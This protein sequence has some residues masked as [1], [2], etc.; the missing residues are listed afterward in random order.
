MQAV[1]SIGGYTHSEA[2]GSICLW[3]CSPIYYFA[4]EMVSL[5]PRSTLVNIHRVD[6]GIKTFRFIGLRGSLSLVFSEFLDYA[7]M[8]ISTG[9]SFNLLTQLNNLTSSHYF[10]LC[11]QANCSNE[12]PSNLYAR[13]WVGLSMKSIKLWRGQKSFVLTSCVWLPLRR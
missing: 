7:E 4:G 6:C 3:L 5:Y 1:R 8:V 12:W 2:G 9:I 10:L 13:A 11:V